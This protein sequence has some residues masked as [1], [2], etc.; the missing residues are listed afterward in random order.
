[1]R[2]TNQSA[3]ETARYLRKAIRKA[4]AAHA[5]ADIEQLNRQLRAIR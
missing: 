1:M 4:Q 2:S 5:T 3:R